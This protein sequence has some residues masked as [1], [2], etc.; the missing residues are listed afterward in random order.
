M[1]RINIEDSIYKDAR[2]IELCNKLNSI[3]M[4]IGAL[5]RAWSIAQ[6]HYTKPEKFIPLDEWRKQRLRDE[7]IEVG[8]A[9][10]SESLIRMAGIDDQF[11]WLLQRQ[12][13]GQKGGLKKHQNNLATDKRPL[14]SAS[15]SKPPPLPPSPSLNDLINTNAQKLATASNAQ[16]FGLSVIDDE[17]E[18]IY[19]EYPRKV[20]KSD[21]FKRLKKSLKTK[22]DLDDLRTAVRRFGA[23]C[24]RKNTKKEYIPYFSTFASNWRD[25]LEADFDDNTGKNS[26]DFSGVTE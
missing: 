10:A 6:R 5:V 8:L 16:A 19:S 18:S 11:K 17:L 20:G 7:L 13:A 26:I 9:T 1:A 25:Y 15:G 14:G 3:D 22:G 21:A 12:A 4:A 24:V 23:Y 2:F